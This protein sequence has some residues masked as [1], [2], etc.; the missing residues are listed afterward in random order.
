MTGPLGEWYYNACSL[1]SAANF[2]KS[3]FVPLICRTGQLNE[4]WVVGTRNSN[5]SES[6]QTKKMIDNFLK[7]KKKCI[8]WIWMLVSFIEKRG[9]GEEEKSK[10]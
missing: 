9:K 3:R 7:K 2:A 10:R 8:S 5:Y 4:K 1:V 6:Q